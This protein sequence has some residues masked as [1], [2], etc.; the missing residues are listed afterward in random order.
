MKRSTD[1]VLPF[2]KD[3]EMREGRVRT[4]PMM[5]PEAIARAVNAMLAE[6]EKRGVAVRLPA[7]RAVVGNRID[8]SATL[9]DIE[10]IALGYRR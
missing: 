8:R 3:R 10:R 2:I 5:P 9:E 6:M 1:G 4:R 7:D